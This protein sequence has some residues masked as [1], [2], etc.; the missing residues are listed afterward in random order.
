M[1]TA[2]NERGETALVTPPRP[3]PQR[4]DGGRDVMADSQFTRPSYADVLSERQK[5]NFWRQVRKGEGCWEWTGPLTADGYGIFT[6]RTTLRAH[7]YSAHRVSWEL[8]RTRIP[9][10]L[11]IDH[12]CRN[13]S[14]VNPS[15][16]EPVSQGVNTLRGY[17][18]TAK[19]ARQTHCKNGHE[20][21]A[22]NLIRRANG[23]RECRTCYN[24]RQRTYW[25][26]GRRKRGAKRGK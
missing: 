15:H 1:E 26:Q 12:L 4:A 25:A 18:P 6:A 19:N 11:T 8:E 20:L 9:D 24:E 14:C 17:G 16:L 10:G 22:P 2:Y 23:R 3:S 7:T 5:A 13:T 21:V